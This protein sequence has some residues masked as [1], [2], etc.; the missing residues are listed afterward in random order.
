MYECVYKTGTTSYASLNP[1]IE[2]GTSH[3]KHMWKQAPPQCVFNE[4][5]VLD[6]NTLQDQNFGSPKVSLR[7]DWLYV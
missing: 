5:L 4:G 1:K 3:C 2:I 7:R 6:T